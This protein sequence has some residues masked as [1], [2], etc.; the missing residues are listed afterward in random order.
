MWHR[1]L[2]VKSSFCSP[3]EKCEVQ[4]N[5]CGSR[6][7]KRANAPFW[8]KTQTIAWWHGLQKHTISTNTVQN[9]NLNAKIVIFWR[10]SL[11]LLLHSEANVMWWS[12]RL[13]L[14]RLIALMQCLGSEVWPRIQQSSTWAD[15]RCALSAV[16]L[17][18]WFNIAAQHSFITR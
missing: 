17:T 3:G 14:Q 10:K 7:I 1:A 18:L 8:H 4:V 16:Y 6:C 5:F 11:C 2:H 12:V 15:L 13:F 9:S